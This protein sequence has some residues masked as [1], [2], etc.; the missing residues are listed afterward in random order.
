MKNKFLL[1]LLTMVM[2][3]ALTGCKEEKEPEKLLDDII[4]NSQE[5]EDPEDYEE[6]EDIEDFD[7]SSKEY[8]VR[9]TDDKLVLVD[10][11]GT[12]YTTFYF[13]GEKVLKYE[14]ATKFP[15]AK[16]AQYAYNSAKKADATQ[17]I[18][19]KGNYLIYTED[20]SSYETATRSDIEATFEAMGFRISK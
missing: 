5:S 17:D 6:R 10:S 1:V 2:C 11:T 16:L 4:N 15:S 9:S 12:N 3:F 14:T 13:D 19:I 7:I 20:A 8:E 18:E